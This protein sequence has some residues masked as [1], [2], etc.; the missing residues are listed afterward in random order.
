V[1]HLHA[2]RSGLAVGVPQGPAA[3]ELFP[4]LRLDG[5][6]KHHHPV[7]AALAF[8]HHHDPA[9][10]V[11]ILDPQLETFHQAHAGA[12][13]QLGEQLLLAAQERQDGCDFLARQHRRNAL[14]R[15]W[16]P[17]LAQ[18][19]QLLAKNLAVQEDDGTQRLLVRGRRNAALVG[20]H[21]QERL[22]LG[23]AY[24]ARMPHA[25]PTDERPHPEQ[26]GFLGR[27]A[28]VKVA[29]A[30][31]HLIEQPRRLERGGSDFG[32]DVIPVHASS[33]PPAKWL[34]ARLSADSPTWVIRCGDGLSGEF[35]DYITLELKVQRLS[36]DQ[37]LTLIIIVIVWALVL[38]WLILRTPTRPPASARFDQFMRW[39]IWH[40]DPRAR[41]DQWMVADP[42]DEGGAPH[43]RRTRLEHCFIWTVVVALVISVLLNECS[44]SVVGQMAFACAKP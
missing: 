9:V 44:T 43:P 8:A 37:W 26:V 35:G 18:P 19:R 41:V 15:R 32:S 11:D 4:Q 21:G 5:P 23:L 40:G 3:R 33:M 7:L 30:L 29:N 39:K 38:V 2:G 25:A 24:V 10:E 34:W 36:S 16:P 28:I 17:D 20:E 42:G 22:D 1:R 14:A 6:R 13:E 27:M 12:I 31:S